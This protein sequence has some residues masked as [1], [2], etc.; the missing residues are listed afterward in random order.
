MFM[1]WDVTLI[2][3]KSNNEE[4]D[5]ISE[6]DK[7]GISPLIAADILKAEFSEIDCSDS[8]WF[9]YETADFEVQI[10]FSNE[11]EVTMYIHILSDDEEPIYEFIEKV[12]RLFECRAF[13]WAEVQFIGEKKTTDK[14]T[15]PE[16]TKKKRPNFFKKLF[17]R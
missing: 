7:I 16:K 2:K 13:D 11:K 4:Y 9:V 10:S 8:A 3:T 17:K 15:V 6:N 14:K 12:C 1:S 5:A